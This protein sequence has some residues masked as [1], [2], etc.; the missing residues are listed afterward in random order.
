MVKLSPQLV[1]I[2]KKLN[3]LP[4]I[5]LPEGYIIRN[6]QPGDEAEWKK[7]IADAFKRE[8]DT[9]N[10]EACIRNAEGFKPERLFFVINS[11]DEVVATAAAMSAKVT[12]KFVPGLH[13][14]GVLSS[15]RGKRLGYWINLAALYCWRNEGVDTVY[16]LTDDDRLPA[17]KTYLN[18]GFEPYIIDD[19]QHA[20]WKNVISN[21]KRP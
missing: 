21:M 14:V 11:E 12:G 8:E 18:L 19:N 10:F 15:C 3:G 13:M 1:M 20:R 4:S 6:F 2:N 9:C 7:I 17:I 5:T 16:L